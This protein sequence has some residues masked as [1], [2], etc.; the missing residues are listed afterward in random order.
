MYRNVFAMSIKKTAFE[1][2]YNYCYIVI[3]ST[4]IIFEVMQ[5]GCSFIITILQLLLQTLPMETLLGK[6]GF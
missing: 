4:K 6:R 3:F 1:R 2:I 5:I